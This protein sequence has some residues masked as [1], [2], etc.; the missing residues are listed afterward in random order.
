MV[1][2][3]IMAKINQQNKNK[4]TKNIKGNNFS[5]SQKLLRGWK[6]L[7]LR[8]DAL[9]FTRNFFV[10]KNKQA[11]NCLNNLKYNTAKL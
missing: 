6:S 11:Q 4:R 10:K 7:V 9:F 2:Q 8:F 5:P 3:K 1:I